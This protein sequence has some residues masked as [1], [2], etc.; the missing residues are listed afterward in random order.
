MHT[1]GELAKSCG[2]TV[3]TVQY[4]DKREILTPGELS[5]GAV[6]SIPKTTARSCK[7]FA[8]CG[9]RTCQSD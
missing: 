8:F 9:K 6:G 7:S 3:R 4:Y 1:T 5:D 2:V